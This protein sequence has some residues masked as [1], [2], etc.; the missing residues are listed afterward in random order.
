MLNRRESID[1]AKVTELSQD[2]RLSTM[3]SVAIF[4]AKTNL[5]ALVWKACRGQTI[6]ITGRSRT[7]V[8]KHKH[9]QR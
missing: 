8:E 7:A 6:I 4:E 3:I 9:P 5:S 1:D 2:S